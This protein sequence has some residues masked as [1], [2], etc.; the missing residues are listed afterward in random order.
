[1]PEYYA[2]GKLLISG[3]YMVL[4]GSE[5]LA[6]PTSKGQ[7]LNFTAGGSQVK[8]QSYDVN[9]RLWLQAS[10]DLKGNLISGDNSKTGFLEN[11]LIHAA[12]LSG[13]L[14][15]GKL[16]SRLEFPQNWGLGSSSTLT[17]LI[18]E[19]SDCDPYLLLFSTQNGSGYDIAC[20]RTSQPI[21]YRLNEEKQ[22]EVT[23]VELSPAFS[24][25]YFVH[26]NEKQNSRPEVDRFLKLNTSEVPTTAI[27]EL[28][29]GFQQAKTV[30]EISSLMDRHEEIMS[31]LL[32][33]PP[34]K[35]R[36][37]PDFKGSVKSLGAWGGDFVMVAGT[38]I[39]DYFNNKGYSTIIEFDRMIYHGALAN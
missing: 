7:T 36:L 1:M 3:E 32:Q 31:N 33:M 12:S 37:F 22:A 2:H 30:E 14:K 4:K 10:F 35:S 23:P 34:V 6:I 21:I 25:L 38:N 13:G 28:T 17:S 29:Q 19:W 5:A 24:E 26:L 27:S 16:T 18:A 11:L 39:H 20:A 15:A 8:W 9:G